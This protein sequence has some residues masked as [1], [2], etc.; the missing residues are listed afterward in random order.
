[1]F[2][3]KAHC[4]KPKHYHPCSIAVQTL[5][6]FHIPPCITPLQTGSKPNQQQG[7]GI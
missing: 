6:D 4:N 7:E 5:F 1:M 2:I 3:R